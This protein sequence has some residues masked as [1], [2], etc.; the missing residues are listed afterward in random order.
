MKILEI[1]FEEKGKLSLKRMVGSLMLANGIIGKNALIVY[2]IY[3][4]VINFERIDNCLDNLIYSGV[5]LL[6]GT[7]ADKFFKK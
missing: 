1:F 6:L 5:A 4:P 7:I 2:A 3:K